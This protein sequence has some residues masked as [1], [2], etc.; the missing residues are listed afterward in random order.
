MNFSFKSIYFENALTSLFQTAQK[1]LNSENEEIKKWAHKV[2]SLKSFFNDENLNYL[3]ENLYE[4][5]KWAL[6][7]LHQLSKNIIDDDLNHL[8][9]GAVTFFVY[10]KEWNFRR[11]IK[12]NEEL[13]TTISSLYNFIYTEKQ[14][15]YLEF[16]THYDFVDELPFVIC[17]EIYSHSKLNEIRK[18]LK[19]KDFSEFSKLVETT[20][21]T[22][23]S[24]LQWEDDFENK[25]DAVKELEKRL[26]KSKQTYDFVLLNKGFKEL[27]EQKKLEL[28]ERRDSYSD[29]ASWLICTPVAVIIISILLVI[30]GFES[31]L[32][33]LWFLAIPI[34][35]LMLFLFYFSRVGLQHIRS[36]QSQMMQLELRMALCQFIHNYAEDSEK[37]H[38]KNAAGFEKF[39]NIIFSPLVSSDDK[40]PTTFDGM[41]Q[42]AKLVNE[43]RK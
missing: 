12:E 1:N 42:L 30:F 5:K 17:G 35:T 33:S 20:E 43:F 9:Y 15:N 38:K 10:L 31:K 39:E 18:F 37:L 23:K 27:Y 24:I 41:E 25:K 6:F 22:S 28:K 36:V 32:H 7:D 8:K 14:F 29:L 21:K 4:T 11:G 40:I 13:N 16:K 34:S 26:E 3:D 2:R 19:E